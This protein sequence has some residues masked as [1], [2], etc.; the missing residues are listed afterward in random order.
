MGLDAILFIRIMLQWM[1]SR[2]GEQFT[3]TIVRLLRNRPKM[4]KVDY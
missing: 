3:A 4:K 1:K 2:N